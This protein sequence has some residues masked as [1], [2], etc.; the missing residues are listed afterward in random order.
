MDLFIFYDDV[1]Y[2]RRGWRNRNRVKTPQGTQWLTI[3]VHAR[4]AQT[5]GLPINTIRTANREWPRQ[6]LE[7]LSRLYG[8]A[9]FFDH[10]A[11]WLERVYTDPPTMLADLTISMVRDIAGMLGISHTMFLRSSALG[12]A[13][14]KTDRLLDVLGKVG[15]THYLSGPSARA[16]IDA[17]Q[18]EASGVALEWME[19]DYPEYRQLHGQY[20]PHVTVL[21]LLFM[22][23]DRARD[24]IWQQ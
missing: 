18:F 22:T 13:G 2:D 6:H 15:A 23:G 7:T 3:P 20:E 14:A 16:Y 11:G 4:G 8:K 12:A 9:P 5:E 24:Y 17:R 21:D 1:Q 19:Y 10:Y